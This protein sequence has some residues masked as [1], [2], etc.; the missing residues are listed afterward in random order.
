MLTAA[1]EESKEERM[2]PRVTIALVLLS[3]LAGCVPQQQYQQELQENQQLLYMNQTYQNLNKSLVS[4]VKND[5]VEIKQ[6]KNKLQ[7][8]LVNDILFPEGGWEVGPRGIAVLAKVAP[9]LQNLNGKEIVVQGYTDNFPVVGDLKARFPT[10]WEL[11]AA[12][13]CN[14]VRHLQTQGVDPAILAAE[15]FGEYHPVAS[16]DTEQ[17]RR[18]NRRIDI[19][20]EDQGT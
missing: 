11:S 9:S 2:K 17:G 20:I 8:T 13:A 7:I 16:N 14:V 15:A 5:Q 1:L 4:E 3:L 12:R 18:K 19:V 6:L 10:N